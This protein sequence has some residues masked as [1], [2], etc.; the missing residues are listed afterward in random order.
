MASLRLDVRCPD[1]LGPFL[2]LDFDLRGE[3]LWRTRDRLKA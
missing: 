1:H 2:K 3:F